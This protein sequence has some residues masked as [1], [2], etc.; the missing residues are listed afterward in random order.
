VLQL[1]NTGTVLTLSHFT[2]NCSYN[3]YKSLNAGLCCKADEQLR[4]NERS[5]MQGSM[6]LPTFF[7]IKIC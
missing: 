1:L 6:V 4:L 5:E 3:D 2:F 7:I